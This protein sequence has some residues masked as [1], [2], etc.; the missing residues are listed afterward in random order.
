MAATALRT[1]LG[2]RSKLKRHIREVVRDNLAAGYGILGRAWLVLTGPVTVIL[3]ASTWSPVMQGYFFTFVGFTAI[4]SLAEL[5]L[6]QVI[7]VHAA[8][9]SVAYSDG[10]RTIPPRVGAITRFCA[11]WFAGA[12]LLIGIGLGSLG[13]LFLASRPSPL[14]RNEW[15]PPWLLVCALLAI[16][17]PISALLFPLE[18]LGQIKLA[19][20]CRMMRNLINSISLWCGIFLGFALWSVPLALA[21]SM[22]WTGIYLAVR[23]QKILAALRRNFDCEPI[24]WRS[25]ILPAQWQLGLSS[26]ADYLIFY[27]FVPVIYYIDGPVAAGQIGLTWQLAAAISAISGM[28][29]A[30][31]FQELSRRLALKDYR[32][33]D[34]V[35]VRAGAT[36]LCVCLLGS[37]A[38]AM[39]VLV[40][41]RYHFALASR[42]LPFGTIVV[43]LTGIVIWNVNLPF[44]SYLRAHGGDP[45]CK[46]NV[47]GACLMLLSELTLGRRFGSTG[48][49]WGFVLIGT[50]FIVPAGA[51]LVH[52]LRN[53]HARIDAGP[54]SAISAYR[55]ASNLPEPWSER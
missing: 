7:I 54:G 37:L 21:A 12:G 50:L 24:R 29:V 1:D 2:M 33:L 15:L 20:F 11:K 32:G 45:F 41:H 27:S 17:L 5:G 25:E 34:R 9:A 22:A 49:A 10:D 18:G 13:T 36:S 38:A 51:L 19:Y 35:T 28:V 40:L 6:G 55:S 8:R 30:A 47:G 14:G 52:R 16:D 48:L 46:A 4:R 26:F 31:K 43:L 44:V 23:G 53:T 39:G 3:L 42:L